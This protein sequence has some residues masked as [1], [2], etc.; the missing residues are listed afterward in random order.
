MTPEYNMWHA[1]P[2]ITG[3]LSREAKKHIADMQIFLKVPQATW[4]CAG[5]VDGQ[6]DNRRL[7]KIDWNH[8]DSVSNWLLTAAHI[9]FQLPN[10]W[11]FTYLLEPLSYGLLLLLSHCL[12]PRNVI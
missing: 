4:I 2:D 9:K 6:S 11:V 10:F 7:I 8:V 3:T 1:L 12:S 5:S